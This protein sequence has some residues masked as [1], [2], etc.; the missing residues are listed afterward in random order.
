MCFLSQTSDIFFTKKT[1]K[2]AWISCVSCNSQRKSSLSIGDILLAETAYKAKQNP[3][4]DDPFI[5]IE[6]SITQTN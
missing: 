3:R 5:L 6:I 1:K 2:K 4:N